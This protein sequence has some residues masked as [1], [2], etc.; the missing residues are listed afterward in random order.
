M[1]KGLYQMSDQFVAWLETL[2]TDCSTLHGNTKGDMASGQTL[3]FKNISSKLAIRSVGIILGQSPECLQVLSI[4]RD[5]DHELQN[6]CD[7][8][9]WKHVLSA[10][11]S[12][13]IA[14]AQNITYRADNGTDATKCREDHDIRDFLDGFPGSKKL[15]DGLATK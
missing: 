15:D 3:H 1:K 9:A 12:Q 10:T 8:N 5:C 11:H 6:L 2:I 14:G 13:S 4:F 7:L